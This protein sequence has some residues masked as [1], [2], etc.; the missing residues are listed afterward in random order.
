MASRPTPPRQAPTSRGRK[1]NT[2]AAKIVPMSEAAVIY[3]VSTTT[4]KQ[5][6][7]QGCPGIMT[8]GHCNVAVI[9]EWDKQRDLAAQA[10]RLAEVAG[11]DGIDYAKLTEREA[12]IAQV[13]RNEILARKIILQDRAL[14]IVTMQMNLVRVAL[15]TLENEWAERVASCSTINEAATLLDEMRDWIFESLRAGVAVEPEEEEA[16]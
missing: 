8:G 9:A 7:D 16:K 14:D 13:M 3:G 10:A 12:Y 15:D 2:A 11:E 4:L 6:R 5:W 1:R